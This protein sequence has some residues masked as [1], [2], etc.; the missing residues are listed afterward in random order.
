MTK[1]GE[2]SQREKACEA[3]SRFANQVVKIKNES[4]WIFA[5]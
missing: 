3:D 5:E 4:T 1:E 2:S